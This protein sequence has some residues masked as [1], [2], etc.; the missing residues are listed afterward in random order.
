MTATEDI[1]IGHQSQ[2]VG[3]Q[4]IALPI[5]FDGKFQRSNND[6]EAIDKEIESD[7]CEND[8]SDD[9]YFV[10]E[11]TVTATEDINIG[12]QSQ[13]VGQQLIALPTQIKPPMITWR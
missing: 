1:N 4:L 11:S 12:H 13:T 5:G 8:S 6:D 9:S 3:Q 10:D 7:Y 2:T